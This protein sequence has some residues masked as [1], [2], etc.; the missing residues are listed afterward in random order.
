M[1]DFQKN[2]LRIDP[3]LDT[4]CEG[5]QYVIA[6]IETWFDVDKKFNVN[7]V[8]KDDTW[9]DFYAKY[10]TQTGDLSTT[11]C[12]NG[13]DSYSHHEYIPTENEKKLIIEMIEECCSKKYNCTLKELAEEDN[14]E[15]EEVDW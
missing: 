12:I 1:K 4:E 7:T 9:V 3:D 6:F 14:I 15:F 8:D 2:E 13:S 11:Y 10:N 5:A